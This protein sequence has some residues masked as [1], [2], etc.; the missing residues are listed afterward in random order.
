MRPY[1]PI[2]P[3]ELE[4]ADDDGSCELLIKIYRANPHSLFP[5]GGKM[6]QYIDSLDIGTQVYVKGPTGY[7][8][9]EGNNI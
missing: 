6:T 2:R 4:G 9:Y 1:T 7:V 3:C 8:L 5:N